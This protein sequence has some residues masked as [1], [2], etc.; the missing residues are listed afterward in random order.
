[1][2][3]YGSHTPEL[4]KLFVVPYSDALAKNVT[5]A[6]LSSEKGIPLA[7]SGLGKRIVSGG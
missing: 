2:E 6:S 7:V 3:A 5:T 4:A 1:M